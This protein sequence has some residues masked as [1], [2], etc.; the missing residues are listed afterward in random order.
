MYKKLTNAQSNA[1]STFHAI[2][3]TQRHVEVSTIAP[4][5]QKSC[6]TEL[7]LNQSEKIRDI[8]TLRTYELDSSSSL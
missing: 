6:S 2:S 3:I 7:F 1:R 4:R 8:T 5:C